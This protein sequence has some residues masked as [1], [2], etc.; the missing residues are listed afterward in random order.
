M[1]KKSSGLGAQVDLT[2]LLVLLTVF[3]LVLFLVFLGHDPVIATAAAS[4]A[5]V[6]ATEIVRR[7]R[8]NRTSMERSHEKRDV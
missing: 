6:S 4:T 5:G 3:G 7:L 1:I 8:N 2:S